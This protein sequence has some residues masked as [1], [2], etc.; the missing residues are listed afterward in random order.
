MKDESAE[1]AAS[2]QLAE[3]HRIVRW[4]MDKIRAEL[5]ASDG[6]AWEA[7]RGALHELRAHLKKRYDLESKGGYFDESFADSPRIQREMRRIVKRQRELEGRLE[8][9]LH[10]VEGNSSPQIVRTE[11]VRRFLDEWI[12]LEQS[13]TGFYQRTAYEEYG[14]GS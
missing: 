4:W 13:E 5:E 12:A 8:V 9:L 6:V 14:G 3:E 7:V 2:E 10:D 1:R 11:M